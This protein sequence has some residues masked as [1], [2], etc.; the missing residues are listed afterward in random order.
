MP[1]IFVIPSGAK[2]FSSVQ[3]REKKETFLAP[4]GMTKSFIF[5]AASSAC[6]F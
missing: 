5:L 4:L 2:N 6:V 1:A 3:V